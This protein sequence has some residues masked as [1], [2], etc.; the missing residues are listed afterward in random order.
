ML[1]ILN[2]TSDASIKELAIISSGDDEKLV[3]FYSEAVFLATE[4]NLKRFADIGVD[5]FYAAKDAVEM[6]AMEVADGVEV[7]DYDDIA[8]LFEDADKIITL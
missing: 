1:Y 5:T 8:G 4:A 3:L 7:V 6:R 2:K